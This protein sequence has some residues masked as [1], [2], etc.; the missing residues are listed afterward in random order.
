MAL[1][2]FSVLSETDEGESGNV[3]LRWLLYVFRQFGNDMSGGW[4][5]QMSKEDEGDD[6]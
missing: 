6:E 2:A 4:L 1:K 3:L 5:S